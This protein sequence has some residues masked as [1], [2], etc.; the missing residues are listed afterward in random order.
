MLR[1]ANRFSD[2]V[3]FAVSM[4]VA[5]IRPKANMTW[6][7]IKKPI[8][9]LSWETNLFVE[10]EDVTVLVSTALIEWTIFVNT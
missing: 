4:R 3:S 1:L 9:L 2:L 6:I 10:P 8:C 5:N 7:V